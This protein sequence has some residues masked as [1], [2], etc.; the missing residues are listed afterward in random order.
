MPWPSGRFEAPSIEWIKGDPEEKEDP[1]KLPAVVQGQYVDVAEVDLEI[2]KSDDKLGIALLPEGAAQK[3]SSIHKTGLVHEWNQANGS[4]IQ[5]GDYIVEVNGVQGNAY[6]VASALSRSKKLKLKVQRYV[7]TAA[8]AAPAAQMRSPAQANGTKANVPNGAKSDVAKDNKQ[9][10]RP[11]E[12]SP[13]E[14]AKTAEPMKQD[15]KT[16]PTDQPGVNPPLGNLREVTRKGGAFAKVDLDDL[17]IG[18]DTIEMPA[19]NPKQEAK[20]A[21]K[22]EETPHDKPEV[23]EKPLEKQNEEEKAPEK[24]K[25]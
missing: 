6:F 10:L 23:E 1:D 17:D 19:E 20:T 12:P 13:K 7:K 11:T 4:K 16:Q 15:R 18:D 14:V 3:I 25:D 21:E 9:Q 24:P 5:E 8:P 2:K 22:K